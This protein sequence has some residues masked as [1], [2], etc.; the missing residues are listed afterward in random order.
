MPVYLIVF[1]SGFKLLG[2]TWRP[3]THHQWILKLVRARASSQ[4]PM[5]RYLALPEQFG[6][7]KSHHF[8]TVYFWYLASNHMTAVVYVYFWVFCC[9][10]WSVS[11]FVPVLGYFCY[12]GS[13]TSSQSLCCFAQSSF[14]L[15][16]YFLLS[17]W[18]WFYVSGRIVLSFWS[19]LQLFCSSLLATWLPHFSLFVLLTHEPGESFQLCLSSLSFHFLALSWLYLLMNRG[20]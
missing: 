19:S 4:D 6:E 8:F 9:T 20:S 14:C 12:Y 2:L 3:M 15:W 18:V 13:E 1:S 10:Q 17:S 16:S 11:I 7:E 5:C